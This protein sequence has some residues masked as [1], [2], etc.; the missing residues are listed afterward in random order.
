MTFGKYR[1][2]RL[3]DVPDDYLGWVLDNCTRISPYLRAAIERELRSRERP[4]GPGPGVQVVLARVR[5]DVLSAVSGWQRRQALAHHPDRG[6]DVRLMQ[7]V[8]DG[9]D[10]L[11]KDIARAFDET[12]V[13]LWGGVAG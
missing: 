10:D 3:A 2:E 7:A 9:A 4:P 5:V 11:R 8:N 12:G 1:S 6:G 13:R